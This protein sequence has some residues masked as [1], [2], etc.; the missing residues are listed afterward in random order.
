[1]NLKKL[2]TPNLHCILGLILFSR[3]S[4]IESPCPWGCLCV[5][6]CVCAIGC[7]YFLGLLLAL[8]SHDQFQASHWPPPPFFRSP[9]HFFSLYGIGNTIRI[10][11][12]IQCFP[13]AIFFLTSYCC[14]NVLDRVMVQAKKILKVA[15]TSYFINQSTKSIKS[16]LQSVIN[17]A[18]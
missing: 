18:T 10:G 2:F 11:Q 6:L 16:Q 5:C 4:V 13:S 9:N 3:N 12:E 8:G 7:S 14:L 1:M 17:I 15:F